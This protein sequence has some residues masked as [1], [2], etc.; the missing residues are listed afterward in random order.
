MGGSARLR[1]G[2]GEDHPP[3]AVVVPISGGGFGHG[4]LATETRG[5]EVVE[6]VEG[7]GRGFVWEFR[8]RD[9][10]AIEHP[11]HPDDA[12]VDRGRPPRRDGRQAGQRQ[13]KHEGKAE[14]SHRL[15]SH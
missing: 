8:G 14:E 1:E 2:H 10:R 7:L 11:V 4:P 9:D 3:A 5:V 13:A 15:V 12:V 6:S